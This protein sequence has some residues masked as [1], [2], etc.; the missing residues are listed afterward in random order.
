MLRVLITKK[1]NIEPEIT[2]FK[3]IR[4]VILSYFE[5]SSFYLRL[6]TL[7]LLI[8]DYYKYWVIVVVHDKPTCALYV[9]YN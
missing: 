8:I 5:F 7:Y 6:Q 2:S 1:D 4:H 3:L 9:L